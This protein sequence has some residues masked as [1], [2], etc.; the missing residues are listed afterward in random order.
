MISI[1]IDFDK[2][3]QTRLFQGQKGRYLD[4]VLFET[5]NSPYADYA[6]KQSTTKEERDKGVDLPKIGDGKQFMKQQPQNHNTPPDD[7]WP[8]ESDPLGL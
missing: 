2:I 3:D 4:L 1:K 7:P 6:V 5:P 8:T